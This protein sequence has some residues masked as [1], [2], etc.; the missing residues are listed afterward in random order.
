MQSATKR[1]SAVLRLT[2]EKIP[3]LIMVA[4][5]CVITICAQRSTHSLASLGNNPIEVRL[6]NALVSYMVYIQ[7]MLWPVDLSVLYPHAGMPPSWMIATALLFLVSISYIAFRK[8]R[9]MPF[10]LVGWL[11]YLGTLVPVIGLV[12]VGSQS[13]ADRYTYLPLVGIFMVVAWGAQVLVES[14]PM[15]KH[16]VL[17]FSLVVLAGFQVLAK[18]QV[19]TWKNSVTLFE[20]ALAVTELNPLAHNNVG[21]AYEASEGSREK[22]L[23]HFM[24]AIELK[25]DYAD[26]YN[27]LGTCA[28]RQGNHEGAIRYF[29]RAAEVDPQYTRARVNLGLMMMKYGELDAAEEQFRQVLKIDTSVEAAHVNLGAIFINQGKLDDATMHLREALRINPKNA[30]AHNNSGVIFLREGRVEE[31]LRHFRQA[32]TVAP[33]HPMAEKNILQI[34]ADMAR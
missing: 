33:G 25:N 24:R 4:A 27:N 22:A 3:F 31:A 2:L 9:E 29:Q 19:E 11:W 21:A 6:A 8:A 26:A 30:D 10:L 15:L 13:M 5:S 7:K 16:P 20:H 23:P 17:V 1:Q 18:P 32:L 34:Q 28:F 14:R 12:Q